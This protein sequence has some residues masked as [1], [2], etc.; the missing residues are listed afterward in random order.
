MVS[1]RMMVCGAEVVVVGGIWDGSRVSSE[2][3]LVACFW[4]LVIIE[5]VAFSSGMD[6]PES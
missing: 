3:N 2:T 4:E 5:S 6:R 1:G